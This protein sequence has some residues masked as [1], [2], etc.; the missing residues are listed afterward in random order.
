MDNSNLTNSIFS[1]TDVPTTTPFW[2]SE[3]EYDN[4]QMITKRILF[5]FYSW[6]FRFSAAAVIMTYLTV[7]IAGFTIAFVLSVMVISRGIAARKRDFWQNRKILNHHLKAQ[8]KA[9][10]HELEAEEKARQERLHKRA[11]HRYAQL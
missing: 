8:L 1:T 11:Q 6:I 10:Q 3:N 4:A 5:T 7:V 9:Y 2:S